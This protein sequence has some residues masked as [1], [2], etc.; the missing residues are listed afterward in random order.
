MRKVLLEGVLLIG[1]AHVEHN[2]H[3]LE[4]NAQILPQGPFADVIGLEPDDLLEI[5]DQVPPVDPSSPV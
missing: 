4:E 3:G 1:S 2:R 5:R